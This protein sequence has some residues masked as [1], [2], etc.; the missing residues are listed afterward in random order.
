MTSVKS[1]HV[2][3]QFAGVVANLTLDRTAGSRSLA[4]AGQRGRSP[5]QEKVF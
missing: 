5:H 3:H 1:T 2:L 4:T